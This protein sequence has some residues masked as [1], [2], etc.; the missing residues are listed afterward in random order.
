MQSLEP[1]H[2]IP[3]VLYP[4]TTKTLCCILLT[5]KKIRRYIALAQLILQH[6]TFT[7]NRFFRARLDPESCTWLTCHL[8]FISINQ[9]GG[10]MWWKGK[11]GNKI[12]GGKFL[13]T[14]PTIELVVIGRAAATLY[15]VSHWYC[16]WY[17]SFNLYNIALGI[18]QWIGAGAGTRKS[19]IYT[20]L[21][22]ITCT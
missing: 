8:C 13:W 11:C 14:W 3:V 12:R 4:K 5:L 10:C 22:L 20:S 17:L 18:E 16:R 1:P 19:Y 21:S 15:S 2:I 6:G 9:G 7:N